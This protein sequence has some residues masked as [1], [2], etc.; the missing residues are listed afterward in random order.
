MSTSDIHEVSPSAPVTP[1]R[2]STVVYWAGTLFVT[3]TALGAGFADIFHAQPL[4]GVLLHL[5]YPAYFATLLGL[6]KVVG[7]VVL[8]APR[9]PLVKEWAY[10]GMLCDYCCAIVSHV[11]VGDGASAVVGPLVALAAL[12]ASWHLRPEARRLARAGVKTR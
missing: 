9:W 8:L 1:S 7:A 6:W 4:Y 11:A 2:A 10:A 3:L 12:A 5:G